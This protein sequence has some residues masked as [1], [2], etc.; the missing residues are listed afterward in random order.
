MV[1]IAKFQFIG[2]PNRAI[3]RISLPEVANAGTNTLG[4]VI[5]PDASVAPE[6]TP[7]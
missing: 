7:P 5:V 1:V 3:I 4:N 2:T 6:A